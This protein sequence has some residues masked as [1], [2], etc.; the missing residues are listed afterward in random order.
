TFLPILP[1]LQRTEQ[2]DSGGFASRTRN[3]FALA[4]S[5]K[6]GII[7]PEGTSPVGITR[8]R[9]REGCDDVAA[10]GRGG[11]AALRAGGAATGP[12]GKEEGRQEGRRD[13]RRREGP[14]AREGVGQGGVVHRVGHDPPG[15]VPAPRAEGPEGR[16]REAQHGGQPADAATP[17]AAAADGPGP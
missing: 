4:W 13:P 11:A 16:R 14:S 1:D 2:L 10:S 6:E 8:R 15:R 7:S 17:P 5:N 3:F 12:E 9:Q